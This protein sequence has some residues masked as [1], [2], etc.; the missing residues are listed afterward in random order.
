MVDR[1]FE[2]AG[3]LITNAGYF[4]RVR[5]LCAS[6][7]KIKDAW[8]KTESELPFGLTRFTHYISFCKARA[9]ESN[10]TIPPPTFRAGVH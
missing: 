2:K 6:G 5:E 9:A 10:G 1:D 4:A 7:Y 3:E 8:E